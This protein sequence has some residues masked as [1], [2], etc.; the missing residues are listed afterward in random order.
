MCGGRGGEAST[1]QNC[2][3]GDTTQRSLNQRFIGTLYKMVLVNTLHLHLKKVHEHQT[4]QS[5]DLPS[6]A[7]AQ[8]H[9]ITL[10]FCISN[11]TRLSANTLGKMLTMGIRLS[12]QT[13]KSSLTSC[14]IWKQV[15]FI[16]LQSFLRIICFTL[17]IFFL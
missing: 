16:S 10:K 3:C 14:F 6:D 12:T 5:L 11:F 15:I 2:W 8:G 17:T 13:I 4:R 7:S 9:V 1:H